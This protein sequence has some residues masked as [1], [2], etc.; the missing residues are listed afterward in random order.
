MDVLR[1]GPRFCRQRFPIRGTVQKQ[2][3]DSDP[4]EAAKLPPKESPHYAI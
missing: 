4:S 2:R 3:H 1:D